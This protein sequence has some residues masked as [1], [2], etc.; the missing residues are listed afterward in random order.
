MYKS[1]DDSMLLEK[2][3]PTALFSHI[4]GAYLEGEAVYVQ[5]YEPSK[6]PNRVLFFGEDLHGLDLQTMDEWKDFERRASSNEVKDQI[7]LAYPESEVS[8]QFEVIHRRKIDPYNG[9]NYFGAFPQYLELTELRITHSDD[10]VDRGNSFL[11]TNPNTKLGS[12]RVTPSDFTRK[13]IT[14]KRDTTIITLLGTMGGV[15]GV[16]FTAYALLFGVKPNRPWGF[17]HKTG[18]ISFQKQKKLRQLEEYFDIK[19]VKGIPLVSPVNQRYAD[20]YSKNVHGI[21]I[22][23]QINEKF[24]LLELNDSK[25]DDTTRDFSVL[26]GRVEQLEGRN[27][28]LELV[29]RAYYIDVE[30]FQQLDR[31][32]QIASTKAE[33]LE[34]QHQ[35]QATCNLSQPYLLKEA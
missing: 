7:F 21:G 26:Q 5:F 30:I 8:V 16:L 4:G 1:S 9:W 22:A 15:A 18:L 28:I 12:I 19:E 31:A 2:Y 20:L 25:T 14:E 6:N 10:S 17:V 33:D 35:S 27:Q 32:R 29:L 34:N 24:P 23:E 11:V 3:N 13:V